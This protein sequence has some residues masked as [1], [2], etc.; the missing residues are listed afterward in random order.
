MTRSWR[1]RASTGNGRLH[2]SNWLGRID[3]S[4]VPSSG[5]TSKQQPA[6]SFQ[7]F[8]LNDS[9]TDAANVDRRAAWSCSPNCV[10]RS[11][12]T[13]RP[14]NHRAFSSIGRPWRGVTGPSEVTA[15]IHVAAMPFSPARSRPSASV[16]MPS[17]VPLR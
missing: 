6:S 17:D 7:N 5:M 16:R 9:F 3:A 10:A 12:A 14:L 11:A 2:D 4:G 8:R 1:R 15:S 13:Q